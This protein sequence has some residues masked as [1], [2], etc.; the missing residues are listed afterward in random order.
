ML[1]QALPGGAHGAV[2]QILTHEVTIYV[3]VYRLGMRV[4]VK[5][6]SCAQLQWRSAAMHTVCRLQ[7]QRELSLHTLWMPQVLLRAHGTAHCSCTPAPF[8][9]MNIVRSL[10]ASSWAAAITAVYVVLQADKTETKAKLA[11]RLIN[12]LSGENKRWSETIKAR[13]RCMLTAVVS[14]FYVRTCLHL[15]QQK[16]AAMPRI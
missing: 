9:R 2:L 1:P 16:S 10:A 8:R 12:G 11:D 3:V 4:D 7:L 6:L 13:P 15:S 14:C 5:R